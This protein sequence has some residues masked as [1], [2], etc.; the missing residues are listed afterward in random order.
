MVSTAVA[1]LSVGPPYDLGIY[2]ADSFELLHTR[3]A[4]DSPYLA[5]ITDVW[6]E[7]LV[8]AVHALPAV[9]ADEIAVLD[10]DRR[11]A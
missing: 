10:P 5:R 1:N 4:G 11:P 8:A 2:H 6:R 3:I 9:E 7:H